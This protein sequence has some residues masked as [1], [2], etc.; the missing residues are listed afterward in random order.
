MSL[1]TCHPFLITSIAPTTARTAGAAA[2]ASAGQKIAAAA[3]TINTRP[4][5]VEPSTARALTQSR[6]IAAR[7]DQAA[8]QPATRSA[9]RRALP[10]VDTA[11]RSWQ[12]AAAC[13]ASCFWR[14]S[15]PCTLARAAASD[16]HECHRTARHQQ[17]PGPRAVSPALGRVPRRV[18]GSDARFRRRSRRCRR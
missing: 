8:H 17:Q 4:R 15:P 11:C 6:I 10:C 13:A 18:T 1:G 7:A 5:H 2:A 9:A 16:R 3:A 12:R 14:S